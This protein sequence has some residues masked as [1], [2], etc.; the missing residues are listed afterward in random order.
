MEGIEKVKRKRVCI[1]INSIVPLYVRG[2]VTGVGRTTFELVEALAAIKNDLPFEI[3]LYSQNLKGIG[4]QNLNLPFKNKHLY[5]PHRK[6]YNN[7]LGKYPVREIFTQYDLLHIPHNFEYV[8]NP[9]KTIVTLHDAL[10]MTFQEKKFNHERMVLTVPPLI[11]KCRAVITCSENSKTDIIKTMNVNPDKIHVIPWGVRHD[12]F[13]PEKNPDIL[14][15]KFEL[16]RPY[17]FSVSCNEERKNTPML[18]EAYMELC[19]NNPV[20]D[21]CLVWDAPRYIREIISS[22]DFHKRIH[23]LKD[24]GDNDLRYLYSGATATIFPSLYEGF[25]LPVLESMACGTPVICSDTTSLP[26]VGGD[27]AVYINPMDS[28][29]IFNTLNAFDKNYFDSSLL[30]KKGINRSA[31]YTWSKCA[32]ETIAVYE[33][34]L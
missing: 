19:K 7:F 33:K 26:E 34:Y 3:V 28:Q 24:V 29:S 25:G 10:F 15:G 18:I 14:T 11:Q 21:L 22:S 20:N 4:G 23:L 31:K 8:Y 12:R 17:F 2:Y 1:D 16:K 6:N 5:L 9:A 27:A 32:Q 30:I 13:F